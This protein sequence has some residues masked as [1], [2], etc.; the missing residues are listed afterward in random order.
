MDQRPFISMRL[1]KMAALL[2][3][4]GLLSSCGW[5]SHFGVEPKDFRYVPPESV[6]QA[7]RDECRNRAISV[8]RS[9][10]WDVASSKDTEVMGTYFGAVGAMGAFA[11]IY[12]AEEVAY[13]EE[14]ESCLKEKGL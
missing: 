3:A 13:T 7:D 11:G 9:R 10:G 2:V 5:G 1:R 14:F 4:G 8:A 6:S 12:E